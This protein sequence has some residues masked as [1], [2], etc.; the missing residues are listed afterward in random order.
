MRAKVLALLM[1]FSFVATASVVLA[2]EKRCSAGGKKVVCPT[3]TQQE[4]EKAA[5]KFE[6]EAM[7][8]M[9]GAAG[10]TYGITGFDY[11][12]GIGKRASKG[13]AGKATL[14]SGDSGYGRST[15]KTEL[16]DRAKK[17]AEGEAIY[18]QWTNNWSPAFKE[19]L[20][21]GASPNEGKQW[22]YMYCIA[23]HGWLLEGDGP[24]AIMLDPY[25]RDLTAGK[26]YMNKKTNVDLFTVIKGGGAAVDLSEAMPA[27]GNLLQ[28]QDIWNVIAW[29]RANADRKAPKT[30]QEYL[31]PKSSYKP[32]ANAVTP[33]NASKD[34]AF[35]E[36]QELIEEGG[37]VAGRGGGLKGGGFVEGGLRKRPEDTKVQGY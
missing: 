17:P 31:N 26:K 19:T 15:G 5:E 36:A 7:D 28:D 24:N 12:T 23:C 32:A 11:L 27:W 33:L 8:M 18:N 34:E 16:W 21:Q 20:V 9:N 10:T 6:K 14:K 2:A 35:M 4:L 37:M 13:K 3:R 1:A 25:P 30:L 29:I 22:Y